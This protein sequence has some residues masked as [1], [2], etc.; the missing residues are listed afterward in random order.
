GARERRPDALGAGDVAHRRQ[1]ARALGR[2]QRAERDLDGKLA[3]VTAQA[4]QRLSAR[5]H[6]THVRLRDVA[7]AVGAVAAARPGR[8]QVFDLAAFQTAARVAEQDFG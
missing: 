7:V 4:Q 8:H 6:W 3:A 5:A 2:L 1:I